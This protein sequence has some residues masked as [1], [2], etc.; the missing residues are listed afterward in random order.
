MS[1][2][3][4]LARKPPS[5]LTFLSPCPVKRLWGE[6]GSRCPFPQQVKGQPLYQSEFSREPEP[7]GYICRFIQRIWL[8]GLWGLASLKS[9]GLASRPEI[10]AGFLYYCLEA[11][12]VLH[13]K[14][15]GLGARGTTVNKASRPSTDRM[16]H[17]YIM[18]GNL[19]YLK[20]IDYRC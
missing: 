16:R 19:L 4:S 1:G 6:S 13:W 17:I 20:S 14:T 11:Q 18:Y 5:P 8:T 15:S 2:W 7:I 9:V 12:L 3:A 10:Q